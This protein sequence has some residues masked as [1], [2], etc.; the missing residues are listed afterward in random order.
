MIAIQCDTSRFQA[1]TR[2]GFKCNSCRQFAGFPNDCTEVVILAFGA[3]FS[4]VREARSGL[5]L[6]DCR[7]QQPSPLVTQMGEILRNARDLL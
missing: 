7:G 1:G 4:L 2:N 3:H 6:H 5:T